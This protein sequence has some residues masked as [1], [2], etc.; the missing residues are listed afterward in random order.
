MPNDTAVPQTSSWAA[1]TQ[2]SE[3]PA[4]LMTLV[5]FIAGSPHASGLYPAIAHG[6]LW[7]GRTPDYTR[8][9]GQLQ[10]SFDTSAQ[11]FNFA[12]VPRSGE[13]RGWSRTCSA[14]EGI[15]TFE[16]IL[17]KRLRWLHEG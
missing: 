13:Q 7:I 4:P 16:R 6:V 9:D 8:G 1:L 12:Y 2:T 17:H 5:R 15:V 3:L 11:E 10:I 14:D